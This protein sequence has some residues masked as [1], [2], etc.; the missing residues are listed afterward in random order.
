MST[1]RISRQSSTP[2]SPILLRLAVL[3]RITTEAAHHIIEVLVAQVRRARVVERGLG[4]RAS[5]VPTRNRALSLAHPIVCAQ[6]LVR[7][8]RRECN[9]SRYPVQQ[10][11]LCR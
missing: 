7:L 8:T 11:R 2:P 6:A 5:I 4:A 9:G 10:K 1:S 3:P